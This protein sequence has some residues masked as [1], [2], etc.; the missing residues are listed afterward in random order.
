MLDNGC[1]VHL[2]HVA[3]LVIKSWETESC[4]ELVGTDRRCMNLF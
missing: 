1:P 3:V 4:V 2:K